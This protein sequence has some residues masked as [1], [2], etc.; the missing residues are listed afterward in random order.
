MD[1]VPLIDLKAQYRDIKVEILPAIHG[2]LEEQQFIPGSQVRAF[3][4]EVAQYSGARFGIGVASGIDALALA[5]RASDIGPGDEVITT[6]F[7]FIASADAITVGGATPVFV[8][9]DP[10]T[11]NISPHQVEERITVG[12]RAI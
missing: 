6:S 9:I 8:D 5:L 2:L 4:K 11:I 12:A 7:S 10:L 1:P 3:E